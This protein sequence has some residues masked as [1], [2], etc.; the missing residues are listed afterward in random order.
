MRRGYLSKLW[1]SAVGYASEGSTLEGLELVRITEILLAC[2][3][4]SAVPA[5]EFSVLNEVLEVIQVR[6]QV[7][8]VVQ[9]AK[10]VFMFRMRHFEFSHV[11]LPP[12][13]K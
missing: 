10:M 5:Y 8:D 2:S 1:R 7:A 6:L 4:P 11:Y 3:H 13:A 9:Q 12:S